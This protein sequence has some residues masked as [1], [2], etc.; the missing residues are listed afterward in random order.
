MNRQHVRLAE[1]ANVDLPRERGELLRVFNPV[2]DL[3]LKVKRDGCHTVL[4]IETRHFCGNDV[5]YR[6]YIPKSMDPALTIAFF[7][8]G[9]LGRQP[10]RD[11]GMMHY[12]RQTSI[13]YHF[14]NEHTD[15]FGE[16]RFTRDQIKRLMR[17]IA[18]DYGIV[19]PSLTIDP[20]AD[21]HEYDNALHN[22]TLVPE[23]DYRRGGE[24]CS[25][26][27]VVHEMAHAILR[28]ID[29]PYSHHHPYFAKLVI[30]M[31]VNYLGY[32]RDELYYSAIQLGVFG[33][34]DPYDP[35]HFAALPQ[36][37]AFLGERVFGADPDV[38][39][40]ELPW[41]EKP[42]AA[43]RAEPAQPLALR[44]DRA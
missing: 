10:Y 32:D 12:D 16:D 28:D 33:P 18:D 23:P 2:A 14:E 15:I 27:V 20:A 11:R 39:C 36:K 43:S 35:D 25:A 24:V 19:C 40:L 44:H 5:L 3:I 6:K 17:L 21:D 41:R 42:V 9:I 7:D 29:C 34:L 4:E 30:D 22:I 38:E 26:E 1:K 31:Y 37:L 13:L 8:L